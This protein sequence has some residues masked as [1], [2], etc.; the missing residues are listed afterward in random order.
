MASQTITALGN[1]II[2]LI[3][4][5]TPIATASTAGMVK[6]DG[7]VVTVDANG[8]LSINMDTTPTSG[9]TNAI[10]SGGVY[11]VLGDIE[12]LLSEV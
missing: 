1:A 8:T 2:N 12:T 6:P 4:S 5:K 10:T 3:N 9:S 11:N 7:S